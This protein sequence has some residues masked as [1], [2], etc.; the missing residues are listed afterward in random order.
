MVSGLLVAN[1]PGRN[2]RMGNPAKTLCGEFV[3]QFLAK[4]T[5][6]WFVVFAELLLEIMRIRHVDFSFVL[7]SVWFVLVAWDDRK[8]DSGGGGLAQ[9]LANVVSERERGPGH[10]C[11]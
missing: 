6:Q 3:S 2:E 5:K 10:G 7:G 11:S 1:P 8:K 9:L 4:L